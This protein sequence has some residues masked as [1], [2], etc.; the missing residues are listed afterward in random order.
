MK[1]VLEYIKFIFFTDNIIGYIKCIGLDIKSFS[2]IYYHK[3]YFASYDD[4]I[5]DTINAKNI[6]LKKI[7]FTLCDEMNKIKD[8]NILFEDEKGNY[9]LE[10]EC[11][12]KKRYKKI[13]LNFFIDDYEIILKLNEC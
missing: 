3:Q 5:K 6:D 1:K 7:I 2:I 10:E 12:I 4:L 13:I 11:D 9:T 8:F